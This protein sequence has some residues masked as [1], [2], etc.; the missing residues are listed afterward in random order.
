MQQIPGL[1][2][3]FLQARENVMA[4]KGMGNDN[5][6]RNAA[7]VQRIPPQHLGLPQDTGKKPQPVEKEPRAEEHKEPLQKG[8]AG[9]PKH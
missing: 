7:R 4:S 8:P 1:S 6:R 9:I 3:I 5:G 2:V